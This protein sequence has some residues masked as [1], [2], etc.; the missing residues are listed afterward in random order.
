MALL[1]PRFVIAGAGIGLFGN[2]A[3]ALDTLR[4]RT[5]PNQ[6][7]WLLWAIAPAVAFGAQLD[8]RVGLQSILTLSSGL[9]PLLVCVAAVV[10]GRSYWRVTRFDACCAIASLVALASWVSTSDPDLGVLLAVV[11]DALAALPTVLKAWRVPE[12]EFLASYWTT[13][14]AGVITMLTVSRW[15]IASTG[16]ALYLIT[17][18]SGIAL[19]ITV[20]REPRRAS[21]QQ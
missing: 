5:R 10:S 18:G 2:G 1:D 14:A 7:S 3:Y 20:R 9:G 15:S 11:A 13:A 17:V 4:G 6:V 21:V 12:T 8:K 16:F 19:I